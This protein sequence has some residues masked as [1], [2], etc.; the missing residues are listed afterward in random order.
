MQQLAARVGAVEI[1]PRI[2]VSP[3]AI[4][5]RSLKKV[6]HAIELATFLTRKKKLSVEVMAAIFWR[7]GW[8]R[9]WFKFH[10]V[11]GLASEPN[12]RCIGDAAPCAKCGEWRRCGRCR[13]SGKL[14]CSRDC[15]K[16]HL[17][18]LVFGDEDVPLS[19]GDAYILLRNL[20]MKNPSRPLEEFSRQSIAG[21]EQKRVEQA[22]YCI[23]TE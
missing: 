22:G 5:A 14:F 7:S 10:S 16:D 23:C 2:G 3:C 11:A 19:A 21:A 18:K 8:T 12:V 9:E 17:K 4:E 13:M 6:E 15:Q 1:M 20:W